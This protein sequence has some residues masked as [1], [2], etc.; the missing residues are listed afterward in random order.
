MKCAS[1]GK[2]ISRVELRCSSEISGI[3]PD[4]WNPAKIMESDYANAG[5]TTYS[6]NAYANWMGAYK[7]DLDRDKWKTIRCPECGADPFGVSKLTDEAFKSRRFIWTKWD[8]RNEV[9]RITRL[10]RKKDTQP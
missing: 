4:E 6:V 9:A 7:K 3:H 5:V 10:I 1:C 2:E 8:N